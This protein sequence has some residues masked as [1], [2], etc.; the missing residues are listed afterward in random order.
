[1]SVKVLK[2]TIKSKSSATAPKQQFVRL[3]LDSNLEQML[4]EYEVQYSLLSRSDIVRMLLSEV[5]WFKKR[6]ARSRL[7][8]MIQNLPAPAVTLDEDQIFTTLENS[9]MM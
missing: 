3:N 4:Q 7:V 2:R 9:D 1:M 8:S 5:Y 6:Q